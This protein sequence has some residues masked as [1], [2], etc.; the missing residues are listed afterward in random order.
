MQKIT[1]HLWFNNEAEDAA[2][3]YCS[4][5]PN[6]FITHIARYPKSAEEISGQKAGSVMTVSFELDGCGFMGLNGGPVFTFTPAISFMVHYGSADEVDALYAKIVDGGKV[7]ME[8][9]TYPFSRRYAWV[10]DRYGVS[11]QII[12]TDKP[13][14]QRIVPSLLFTGAVSGKAEEAMQLYVS[15]FPNSSIGMTARYGPGQ[16]PDA[17]GTLMYGDFLLSGQKFAAMDSAYAHAFTFN[18]AVS[19]LVACDDQEEIDRLFR[20]LSAVPEAEQCGWIKDRYGVPWQITPR[21]MEEL[22]TS[23]ETEKINRMTAAMLQM[24]KLDIKKLKDAFDGVA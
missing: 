10:S 7:L 13:I 4:L 8:L 18:E 22:M 20:A 2:Q 11:W 23:G 21:M 17:E 19:F 14:T 15:L 12:C 3:F 6:S 24:K 5:F 1:P 16:A 9:G